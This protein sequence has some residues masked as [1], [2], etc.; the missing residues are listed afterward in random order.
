MFKLTVVIINNKGLHTMNKII[1]LQTEP[2]NGQ[3]INPQDKQP[4]AAYLD[5][6]RPTG[7]RSQQQA[8]EVIAA[9]FGRGV[10][11]MQWAA[12]RYGQ[13]L[14]IK[15]VLQERYNYSTANKF[16]SALRGV[17]KQA[18]KLGLMTAEDYHRAADIE[19]IKGDVIPAG[20]EL[21]Q[22]EIRAIIDNCQADQT[23]AGVRDGA[24]FA[25]L[26]ATGV[27]REEIIKVCLSD[28]DQDT[29]KIIITGKRNKQRAVYINNGAAD[30]L[31]DWLAIRGSDPGAVFLPITKSGIIQYNS[32]GM[33]PQAVYY[34]L[35][36]RATAAKVKAFSPHDLR[37]TF[38]SN[39][40]EAGADIAIIAKIAG[41]ASVNTTARYDR[42]PEEAKRKAAGLLH[43]P[44][45]KRS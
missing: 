3:V 16:L 38:I 30:A 26:Y 27:R 12:L 1:T 18:Y 7:R 9:M 19:N 6:L 13:T 15:S 11:D 31:A 29:G 37:R 8:L 14:Q 20:R 10:D 4:A 17:L 33:T 2:I 41:H 43:I 45:K 44:Y 39:M 35:Q 5:Q 32:P 24:L 36:K 42:R 22:A 25:V 21:T 40:L 28:Y 34:M 23:P